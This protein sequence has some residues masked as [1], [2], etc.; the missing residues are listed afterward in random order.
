MKNINDEIRKVETAFKDANA[1]ANLC[2]LESCSICAHFFEKITR[3]QTLIEV[4]E[5]IEDKIKDYE[6]YKDKFHTYT[7]EDLKEILGGSNG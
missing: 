5:L 1:H 3:L 4:K 6:K 7:K 2:E